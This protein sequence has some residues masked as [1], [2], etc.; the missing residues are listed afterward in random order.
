M[1]DSRDYIGLVE[2]ARLGD[3]ECLNR[4]AE[5]VRVRLAEYVHRLTLAEDLTQDIVQESIL[6]MY[7]KLGKLKKAEKFWSWLYGIAFNKIRSHYGKQWRQ[8]TVSLCDVDCD[9]AGPNSRDGLAEMV[10]EEWRLAVARAMLDLQP[11]HRAVLS[12]RCYDKM[13]YSH[14]A[15]VMGS[16]ELGAQALFYRAKKSLAKMLSR[17]G[18]GKGA[19]LVALMLFG[20]MTAAS[21][22]AAGNV[23]VTAATAKVSLAGGVVGMMGGKGVLV[24]LAAVGALAV[25]GVV[26]TSGSDKAMGLLEHKPAASSKVGRVAGGAP[27][28]IDQCWYYF[29]EGADGPVMMRLV[30]DGGGR[31]SDCKWR[32]NDEANYYYDMGRNTVYLNN[33][34]LW[35]SDLRVWRLPTDR[36]RLSEFLSEVEGGEP[37]MEY[38]SGDGDGLLVIVKNGDEKDDSHSEM[39]YHYNMLE[40]QYFRYNLPKGVNVVDNRDQ[41]HKRGWTYFRISGEIA[42]REVTGTGCVP[43]VYAA[44]KVSRPRLR[45][46]VGDQLVVDTSERAFIYDG[47]GSARESYKGGSFF[48]GLARPWMGL[49]TIDT[50]RRD[51]AS[52]RIR[53]ETQVTQHGDKVEITLAPARGRMIFTVDMSSDVVERIT[54]STGSGAAGE[55]RF[56]YLQGI[57]DFEDE[58]ATPRSMRYSRPS[59]KSPGVLWLLGL[60]EHL[61]PTKAA[62]VNSR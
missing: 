7:K 33:H 51:A 37:P 60:A 25:G 29:P 43:F 49:H 57:D 53:F 38:V 30:G 22:A 45:L 59:R 18:F 54:F 34:R 56:A 14:I 31:Q 44:S 50:I 35:R 24:S 41:M 3:K 62:P 13:P 20:K 19:M 6:E 23:S 39:T 27:E 52:E 55:L 1:V 16:T 32:Q 47:D 8:K 46:R 40:E 9:I 12:M 26:A 5:V 2:K 28:K 58:F 11:R 42:G 10:A 61:G 36:V 4:L 17:H 15:E 21:K 48:A